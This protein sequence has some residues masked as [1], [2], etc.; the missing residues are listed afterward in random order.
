MGWARDKEK[1]E[2]MENRELERQKRQLVNGEGF[3][4]VRMP[5]SQVPRPCGVISILPMPEPVC[6][7]PGL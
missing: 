3:Y 2:I 7:N 1:P 5:I 4:G 6:S